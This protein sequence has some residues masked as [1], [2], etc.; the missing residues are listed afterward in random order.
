MTAMSS[1]TQG[2]PTSAPFPSQS[3]SMS[4]LP[5]NTAELREIAQ[6]IETVMAQLQVIEQGT[7]LQPMQYTARLSWEILYEHREILRSKRLS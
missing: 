1:I 7:A 3:L 2:T 5:I 6:A 4:T